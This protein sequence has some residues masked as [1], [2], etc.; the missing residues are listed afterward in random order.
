MKTAM[1]IWWANLKKKTWKPIKD[2]IKTHGK[3]KYR[4]RKQLEKDG[5]REVKDYGR[6][7]RKHIT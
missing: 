5:D 4:M 7:S 2:S 3:K 1:K 6:H